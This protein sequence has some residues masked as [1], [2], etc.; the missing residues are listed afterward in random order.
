MKNGMVKGFTAVCLAG[1][2]W[3]GSPLVVGAQIPACISLTEIHPGMQ[4][5]AVTVVDSSGRKRELKV[6]VMDVGW[7]ERND[8]YVE[9]S[10]QAA[11]VDRGSVHGFSGSPVYID[12]KLAGALAWHRK[13]T[14]NRYM[15]VTPI[16]DMLAIF[17]QPSSCDGSSVKMDGTAVAANIAKVGFGAGSPVGV[18]YMIG[19]ISAAS[20]GTVTL[21]DGSRM[22]AFGHSDSSMKQG[23]VNAFMTTATV[24]GSLYGPVDGNRFVNFGPVIGRISQNTEKGIA[25]VIGEYPHYVPIRLTVK[26]KDTGK[27]V[28]YQSKIAYNEEMIGK[29]AGQM[30]SAGIRKEVLSEA[31]TAAQVHFTIKAAGVPNGSYSYEDVC[32]RQAGVNSIAGNRLAQALGIILS[33]AEKDPDV[34]DIDVKVVVSRERNTASIVKV[35]PDRSTVRPGET[36]NLRVQLRPFRK[37]I[38]TVMIPYTVPQGQPAGVMKLHLQGGIAVGAAA[39]KDSKVN[40]AAPQDTT[41]AA[42]Q[43]T[44]KRLKELNEKLRGNEIAVTSH[45]AKKTRCSTNY[46]IDNT[47]D[48]EIYIQ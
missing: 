47:L 20:S 48:T 24:I 44:T 14:Y 25:G 17:D 23:N 18:A 21:V 7:G 42:V 13:E 9:F 3:F 22:L 19:D 30:V 5:K 4:G 8:I 35:V 12:G 26:D 27:E 16:A 10:G 46:A 11:D 41:P 1:A 2:F 32:Y 43:S 38:E 31:G 45:S 34:T 15:K 37:P 28:T 29:L 36:V 40:A 33:D 6:N 39:G